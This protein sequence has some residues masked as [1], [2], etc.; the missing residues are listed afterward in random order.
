[1]KST[2]WDN[3]Q[4]TM[5]LNVIEG[6]V[7]GRGMQRHRHSEFLRFLDAVEAAVPAVPAGKVV[8]VV[9]DN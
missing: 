2:D 1:M 7:I 3:K 5:A 9:L 4:G 8:H 6:T